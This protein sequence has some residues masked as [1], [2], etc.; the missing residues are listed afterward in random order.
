LTAERVAGL[1]A[2][3]AW[4]DPSIQLWNRS[5]LANLRYGHS[6]PGASSLAEVLR[7]ADLMPVLE[8]LPAG[9]ETPLGEGGCLLSGGEGQRARLGRA[10]LSPQPRLVILDE[11]FRG[12]DR[13]QRARLLGEA[14]ELWRGATLLVITH[15][16]SETLSFP[17]V[18]VVEHGRIAEDGS[19]AELAARADSRYGELL[20][21]ERN[22][23]AALWGNPVW[24]RLRMAD[25]E[26]TET[27]TR[28]AQGAA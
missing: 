20:A 19:P 17:R 11:P 4:V 27:H 26:L 15:D 16:V 24:R 25:G 18:V 22:V 21:A 8:R 28:E 1:R 13:S 2:A 3:T 7:R 10:L 5:L 23:H 6:A 9:L 12:L 14:R